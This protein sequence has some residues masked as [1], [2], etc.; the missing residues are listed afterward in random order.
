M[1]KEKY[2]QTFYELMNK[3][4]KKS[5]EEIVPFLIKTIKPQKVIDVG[6]GIGIW[7]REFERQGIQDFVGFD[8][9]WIK[10][11]DLCIPL[12]KFREVDFINGHIDFNQKSPF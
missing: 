7:L 11:E 5:A 9:N 4:T 10:K 8:G 6:C 1:K 12:S 3:T 2:D